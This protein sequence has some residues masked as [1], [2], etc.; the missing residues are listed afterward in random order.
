M[1]Y[2]PVK[3]YLPEAAEADWVDRVDW[4]DAHSLPAGGAV[5][6]PCKTASKRLI[7]T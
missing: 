5:F 7:F 4:V 1:S 3:K 2:P 6:A